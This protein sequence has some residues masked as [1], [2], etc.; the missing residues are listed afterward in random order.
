MRFRR[1]D[2]TPAGTYL[3]V[4]IPNRELDAFPLL[5]TI[6]YM[7]SVVVSIPNRELDAFP[8]HVGG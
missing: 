7:V 8:P 4:S 5:L 6:R 1:L 3:S 2:L